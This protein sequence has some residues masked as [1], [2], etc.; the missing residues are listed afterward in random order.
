MQPQPLSLGAK[1]VAALFA[2]SSV[3]HTVRPEVFTGTI[4]AF[5]P[6][7]RELVYISGAA[8]LLCAV[9]L[10]VPRTRPVAAVATTALLVAIF[11]ANLQMAWS[12]GEDFVENG[13]SAARGFTLAVALVR[14]PLQWPMIRWAWGARDSA[15]RNSRD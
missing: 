4:P 10:I 3:L 12:A 7:P 1:F 6:Y 11:P 15:T 2:G 5:L 13:A 8:E 14:L 9:G